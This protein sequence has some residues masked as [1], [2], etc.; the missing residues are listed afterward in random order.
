M[1]HEQ[2]VHKNG[3][4]RAD[5]KYT[6]IRCKECNAPF[7]DDITIARHMETHHPPVDATPPRKRQ[8]RER[9]VVGTHDSNS[10]HSQKPS[11]SGD[12]SQR[13]TAANTH[14]DELRQSMSD[15]IMVSA[16][17][18]SKQNNNHSQLHR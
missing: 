1:L 10:D 16:L 15:L 12:A 2:E 11:A 14:T 9:K 7:F 18:F 8:R 17:R 13:Q 6:A 5:M 4:M 3:I